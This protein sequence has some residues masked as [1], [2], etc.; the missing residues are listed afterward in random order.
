MNMHI[1]YQYIWKMVYSPTNKLAISQVAD[2]ST[3][4]QRF[5]NHE[6]TTE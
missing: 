4:R 1:F 2:W 5:I 6:K 3:R